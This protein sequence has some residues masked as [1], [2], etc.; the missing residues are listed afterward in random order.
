MGDGRDKMRAE[1]SRIMHITEI[2]P[3]EI[4]TTVP[5]YPY[6]LPLAW[7]NFTL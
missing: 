6:P 3:V 4:S 5:S 7:I 2:S 1:I